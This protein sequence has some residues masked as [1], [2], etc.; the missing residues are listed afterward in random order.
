MALFHSHVQIIARSSG[1]SA[2]AAAAYRSGEQLTDE[3]S[4]IVHDYSRRQNIVCNGIILPDSAPRRWL[5]RSALWNDAERS[6]RG[7]NAQLARE[8]NFALPQELS[9][10][11]QI[12]LAREYAGSFAAEGMVADFAVHDPG[13]DGHNV[14]AHMMLTMRPCSETGF[15]PKSENVYLVRNTKGGEQHV[16]AAGFKDLGEE[17]GKVFSYKGG[18]ELTKGEAEDAGL[19][20]I[21]DRKRKQPIQETRYL[22]DWNDQCKAEEWRKRLS[23]MQNRYLADAGSA[24]RVDHRSFAAKSIDRIPTKHEGPTV[25]HIEAV[26]QARA[27]RY[28]YRYSPIT[29]RRRENI[30]IKAFNLQWEQVLRMFLKMYKAGTPN[31]LVGTLATETAKRLLAQR[32][33]STRQQQKNS[34]AK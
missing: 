22:C 16:N 9:R 32:Q 28:G 2:V 17:W 20:P 5:D 14:H 31:A 13:G 34:P 8:I 12:E 15:G 29:D 19:D 3:R 24:E 18:Y 6:E 11:E 33:K 26:A 10:G 23:D 25:N 21:K 1:R 27:S 4:G 7:K 30:G